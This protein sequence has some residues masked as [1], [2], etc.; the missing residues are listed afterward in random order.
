MAF[1]HFHAFLTREA[2]SNAFIKLHTL[3]NAGNLEH[4]IPFTS[5]MRKTP[6]AVPFVT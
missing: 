5:V 4:A 3:P 2:V 6:I 1:T